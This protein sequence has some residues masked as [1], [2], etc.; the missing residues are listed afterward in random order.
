MDERVQ[1]LVSNLDVVERE[2]WLRVLRACYDT[3]L[4]TNNSFAKAW[5]HGFDGAIFNLRRL[6]RCGLLNK[7]MTS[8]RGHRAYWQLADRE[9]VAAALRTLGYL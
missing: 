1:R 2:H 3:S 4:E 5:L 7:E 8:R 9:A 6:E